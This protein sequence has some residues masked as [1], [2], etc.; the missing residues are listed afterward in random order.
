MQQLGLA[1]A[2]DL[3]EHSRNVKAA[4]TPLP[5]KETGTG[6]GH[7]LMPDPKVQPSELIES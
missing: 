3:P 6:M 5:A 4:L 7:N 2:A 1:W